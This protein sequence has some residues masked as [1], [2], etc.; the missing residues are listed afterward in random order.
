MLSLK[1]QKQGAMVK[2]G[3]GLI[4][5]CLSGHLPRFS[6]VSLQPLEKGKRLV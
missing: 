3:V 6:D 2:I 4:A 5:A 1:N